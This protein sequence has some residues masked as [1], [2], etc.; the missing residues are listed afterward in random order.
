MAAASAGIIL[1]QQPAYHGAQHLYQAAP[2]YHAQPILKTLVHKEHHE[3]DAHPQYS[4]SY[5]VHDSHT[6][7]LKNQHETRDGDVVKGQYSLIE[8]DGTRRIVD[9][10]ADDIHG[11][12]AVVTKEGVPQPQ[13]VLKTIQPALIKTVQPAYI[14]QPQ[15]VHA[16]PQYVHAQPQYNS[17]H[18]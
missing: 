12:N 1:D 2:A 5:D 11:F 3:I 18:H 14:A 4:F 6:G 8:A 13:H 10:T 15:Y 16:Q 17:Y 7:D 9:Y